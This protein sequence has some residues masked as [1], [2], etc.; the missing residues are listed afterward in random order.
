MPELGC[1]LGVFLRQSSHLQSV[2]SVTFVQ[3]AG[4]TTLKPEA[5]TRAPVMA[6]ADGG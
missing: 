6:G 4:T 1:E 2:R 3:P 5:A